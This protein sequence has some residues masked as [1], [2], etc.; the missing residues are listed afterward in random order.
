MERL[1]WNKWLEP[2]LLLKN[3][4]CP[5]LYGAY[6]RETCLSY[7]CWRDAW[8]LRVNISFFATI[9]AESVHVP[10]LASL[11]ERVLRFEPLL[12]LCKWCQLFRVKWAE[13]KRHENVLWG[14]CKKTN[15]CSWE[16]TRH[17]NNVSNL[18]W[19]TQMLPEQRRRPFYFG[20]S[21]SCLFCWKSA[22]LRD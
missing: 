16:D 14:I 10:Q 9:A 19:Y 8:W 1:F 7:L 13:H 2:S 11:K 5:W 4:W 15:R 12:V 18:S 6:N 22:T 17:E 20:F 21:A 3:K